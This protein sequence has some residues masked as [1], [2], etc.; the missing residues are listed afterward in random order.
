MLAK[1]QVILNHRKETAEAIPII[2]EIEDLG[3]KAQF[4]VGDIRSKESCATL[5]SKAVA[6]V[7]KIDICVINPGGGWHPQTL[8]NLQPEDAFDDLAAEMAPIFNLLPIVLPS[9]QQQQ[10]GRI[11]GVSLNPGKPSPA[12]SYNMAKAAR[13][14]ALLLASEETWSTG[15]TINVIAPG[16]VEKF[17]NLHEAIAFCKKSDEWKMRDNVTPQDIAEGVAFLCSEAARFITGCALTYS[18]R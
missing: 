14:Q 18:Y 9:M 4:I 6:E 16:P 2:K 17:E 8:E 13:T 10:W 12:L 11:I 7:G 5:I 15:V 1:G 3:A